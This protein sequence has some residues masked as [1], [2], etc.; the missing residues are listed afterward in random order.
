MYSTCYFSS[1]GISGLRIGKLGSAG[2]TLP[3]MLPWFLSLK[4]KK[5]AVTNAK[6]GLLRVRSLFHI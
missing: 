1:Q 3:G 4:L 2:E 5:D 6:G